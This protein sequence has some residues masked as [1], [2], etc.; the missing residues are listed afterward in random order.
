MFVENLKET[1]TSQTQLQMAW[2]QKKRMRDIKL[3]TGLS[4]PWTGFHN[5]SQY[6]DQLNSWELVKEDTA[7]WS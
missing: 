3:Q 5:N 1:G 7:L 4:W 6:C 2:Q